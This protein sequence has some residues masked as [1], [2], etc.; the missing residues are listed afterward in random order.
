LPRQ[1]S[2]RLPQFLPDGRHFL[3]FAQGSVE[4]QGIYLASLDGGEVKRLTAADA[5]GAYTEPGLLIFDNQGALLGRHLDI[6][7]RSLTGETFTVAESVAYDPSF[8]LA[9]FSVSA[10]GRIAYRAG[11]LERRQL[12][13][14]DRTGRQVGVAGDVDNT[15]L[16]VDIS[17]NGRQLAVSRT[18]QRNMDLWLIDVLRGGAARL[19][20]DPA[21]DQYGT[22]APDGTQIAFTSNRNGIYDIFATA[23][24]GGGTEELLLKSAHV[25]APT[26]WSRDGQFILF[27][28]VDPK[29]SWDVWA[30]PT[31]GERKPFVVVSTP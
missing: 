4:G 12:T 19:T 11:G 20:S 13:W 1:G 21:I 29:N 6:T 10:A 27:Q 3:F 2:H 22:W 23:S 7:G 24:N 8:N 9:A 17:P 14:F 5:A 18:V 26:D 31:F 15:V 28:D 30:L 25:K 16:G